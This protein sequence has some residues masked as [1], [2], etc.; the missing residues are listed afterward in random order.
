LN[1]KHLDFGCRINNKSGVILNDFINSSNAVI[2]NNK[3]EFTY[4]RD[5]TKYREILDLFIC[6][7]CL[8][9]CIKKCRVDYD[10]Q[11]QSDHIPVEINF[12]DFINIECEEM[13][14]EMQYNYSKANWKTFK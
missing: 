13:N 3:D 1:A 7:S 9:S 10:S 12:N 5:K 14:V 6:S 4:F 2:L 11:L 8:Y